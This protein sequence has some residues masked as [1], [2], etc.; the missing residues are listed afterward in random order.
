MYHVV[1]ERLYLGPCSAF[2]WVFAVF[3][4]CTSLFNADSPGGL[5]SYVV[6]HLAVA[7]LPR[8]VLPTFPRARWALRTWVAPPAGA[9]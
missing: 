1:D 8:R 9:A 4:F 6:G 3:S 7:G 2:I 5:C